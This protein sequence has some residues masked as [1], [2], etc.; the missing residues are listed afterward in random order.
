MTTADIVTGFQTYGPTIVAAA[1]AAANAINALHPKWKDNPMFSALSK[2]V[3]FL[4]LNWI[5]K[6][7]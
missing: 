2:G 6:K 4:A 1:S 3:D 7:S 5:Q